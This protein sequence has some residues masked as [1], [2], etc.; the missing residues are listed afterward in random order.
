MAIKLE[1]INFSAER[2]TVAFYWPVPAGDQLAGA[3]D[4][5]RTPAGSALSGPELQDLIDGKLYEQVRSFD[6]SGHTLAVMRARLE[7]L[8]TS[9]QGE[10]LGAYRAAYRLKDRV[11]STWDGASWS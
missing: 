8:W 10:A 7:G 5:T 1:I 6:T 3:V 4:A 9:L 11:G 2:V